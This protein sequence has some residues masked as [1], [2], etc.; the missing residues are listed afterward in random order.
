[1]VINFEEIE[2]KIK[3]LRQDFQTS[4]PFPWVAIDNFA[5]TDKLVNIINSFPNPDNKS[6][7][8]SRDYIFA[9]NKYETSNFKAFSHAGHELHKDLT[10][11]RF[12]EILHSI[13]SENVFVD[14][15]FHGGGA[16]Q[17]GQGSFLD[18]H[19]DFNY[20]PL[21]CNWFRNLNLLL[22]LNQDWKPEYGGQLKLRS[23]ITN[24][25]TAVEPLFNRCVV[26]LTRDYTLHGYDTINF[27]LGTF[28]RSIATYAYSIDE[29]PKKE[30]STRWMPENSSPLKKVVGQY[31]P[32][33]VRIK[34][35]LLGSG[36]ARNK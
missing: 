20:H 18:M 24:R 11:E 6:T 28:R 30:R 31:W 13:T 14:H 22:Y 10:S 4:N 8:K 17:G 9:K 21:H 36:T 33:L 34:G 19:V 29:H 23:S 7:N 27:P 35:S 1:M 16:H 15:D 5:N 26:M 2:G 12:K 32:E 25:N 3:Y